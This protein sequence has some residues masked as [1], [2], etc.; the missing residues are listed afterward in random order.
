MWTTKIS[1]VKSR[2]PPVNFSAAF[3]FPAQLQI[4][5]SIADELTCEEVHLSGRNPTQIPSS[6][7]VGPPTSGSKA[8]GPKFSQPRPVI[9]GWSVD[10]ERIFDREAA[11]INL[12]WARKRRTNNMD[13]DEKITKS[14][15]VFR[16][17]ASEAIGASINPYMTFFQ[18]FQIFPTF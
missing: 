8:G 3:W 6:A 11:K 5:V 18:I 2:R 10:D 16:S 14:E 9:T 1:H 15:W 4:C 12:K 13:P 7:H 17:V